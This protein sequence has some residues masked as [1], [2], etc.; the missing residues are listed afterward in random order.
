MPFPTVEIGDAIV[1]WNGT[2][3]LPARATSTVSGSFI[4]LIANPL[5]APNFTVNAAPFDATRA[6]ADSWSWPVDT[7]NLVGNWR[8]VTG[9][10]ATVAATDRYI[11]LSHD[12]TRV[13][14]LLALPA[15]TALTF[16]DT[17]GSSTSANTITFT[18]TPTINATATITPGTNTTC[19][20]L[21]DGANYWL[22]DRF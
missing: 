18:G 3:A 8:V 6:T 10:T 20:L 13:V 15:G 21:S 9:D 1:Y 12:H 16:M 2:A 4:S 11:A 5:T 17:S 19:T 14:T 22:V 7:G